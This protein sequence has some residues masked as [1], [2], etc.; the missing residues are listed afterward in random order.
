MK[1]VTGQDVRPAVTNLASPTEPQKTVT[2]SPPFLPGE[3]AVTKIVTE[4][5]I[6][7]A[8]PAE[9]AAAPLPPHPPLEIS[10]AQKI[11]NINESQQRS[12]DPKSTTRARA[13]AARQAVTKNVTGPKVTSMEL[14]TYLDRIRCWVGP[15]DY[16]TDSSQTL[17]R[18]MVLTCPDAV[19]ATLSK[20]TKLDA[21]G[22]FHWDK[23]RDAGRPP[24]QQHKI[25]WF[26]TAVKNE[27]GFKHWGDVRCGPEPVE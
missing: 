1:T 9:A 17:Y 5:S 3:V 24:G 14:A 16:E 25:C 27:A 8:E 7:G 18:K 13:R 15:E 11:S 21:T 2:V 26:V 19:C 4:P 12:T 10:E 22:Y 23:Q 20:A 6:T